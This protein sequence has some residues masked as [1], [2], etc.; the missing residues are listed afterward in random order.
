MNKTTFKETVEWL[1]NLCNAK[2]E[3]LFILPLM[4]NSESFEEFLEELGDEEEFKN[5]FPGI[6]IVDINDIEETID[7]VKQYLLQEER[8]GFI[9]V[10]HAPTLIAC[11]IGCITTGSWKIHNIFASSEQA[12]I[13][14][15]ETFR[16]NEINLALKV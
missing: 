14:R 12:L 16:R 8:A 10:V 6:V 5:L 7:D 11:S 15:I 9:A 13:T 1:H 2:I 4:M 3:K